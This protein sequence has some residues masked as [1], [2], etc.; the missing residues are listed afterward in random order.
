MLWRGAC[1]MPASFVGL[2]EGILILTFL[3]LIGA[4]PGRAAPPSLK[5]LRTYFLPVRSLLGSFAGCAM[6]GP[7]WWAGCVPWPRLQ[8]FWVMILG[9]GTLAQ[10]MGIFG[11]GFGW[12]L[13]MQYGRLLAYV[14]RG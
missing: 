4:A 13:Y 6:F 12:Q 5:R 2:F 8:F 3:K 9:F 1:C 14:G 11:R 7:E 10:N